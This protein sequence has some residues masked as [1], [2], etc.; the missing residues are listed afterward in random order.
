M[1]TPITVTPTACPDAD[2]AVYDRLTAQ[3]EAA[4]QAFV[5]FLACYPGFDPRTPM[6]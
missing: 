5:E 2:F 6:E 1:L 3:R 4:E